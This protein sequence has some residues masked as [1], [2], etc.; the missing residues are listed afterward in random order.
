ML[1]NIQNRIGA[2]KSLMR[3]CLRMA[4]F[5]RSHLKPGWIPTFSEGRVWNSEELYYTCIIENTFFPIAKS[6]SWFVR[7]TSIVSLLWFPVSFPVLWVHETTTGLMKQPS[8]NKDPWR[9]ESRS[10]L[11]TFGVGELFKTTTTPRS[12]EPSSD[13]MTLQH[14]E[15]FII[16]T[17]DIVIHSLC[18]ATHSTPQVYLKLHQGKTL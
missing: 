4:D 13:K 14:L 8:T 2:R 17:S 16:M 7:I 11:T 10:Q 18:L 15:R 6:F 9:I 3:L 12:G 5:R 1:A